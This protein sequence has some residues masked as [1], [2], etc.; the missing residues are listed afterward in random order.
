M[1][2]DSDRV[3][4][5]QPLAV[6]RSFYERLLELYPSLSDDHPQG[7]AYRGLLQYILFSTFRDKKTNRTLVPY[8]TVAS[9]VGVSPHQRGFSALAWLSAFSR[10]VLPLN[11]ST[12]RYSEGKA[13]VIAP[14]ISPAL[15]EACEQEAA[16]HQAE[17]RASER[18]WFDSGLPV[19]RRNQRL[20][21]QEYE[22]YLKRQ[23]LS[24]RMDHPARELLM[25]LVEQPQD[26]LLKVLRENWPAVRAAV[27][28]MPK[29]TE[30]E[31]MRRQWC[32]LLLIRLDGFQ[33]LYYASSPKTPRLFTI[34]ANL[35]QFPRDLR[36]MALAGAVECD[37]RAS[38]LAVVA[39]LWD[40]PSLQ[41]YL[42]SGVSVWQDLADGIGVPLEDYKPI[43]KAS[44]YSI[45][46]GMSRSEI[47]WQLAHGT[48]FEEGVG[49]AAAGRF[50]KLPIIAP[51][52]EARDHMLYKIGREC[53][54]YDAWGRW[55]YTAQETRPVRGRLRQVPDSPSVLSAIVQ[56]YELKIMLSVL[57]VIKSDRQIYLLSW[58]HDGVTLLL[59]NK[60]K[61]ER[62]IRRLKSVVQREAEALQVSTW[63]E[64]EQLS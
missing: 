39:R 23:S 25:Y 19:S 64:V 4:R 8:T 46:F 51:L 59:G 21:A 1:E 58:L 18:V 33:K 6:S 37:L 13:R 9:L 60:T 62:Y 26:R 32:E 5:L 31:W 49:Q 3:Y 50:L 56:S 43:L 11:P 55:L 2:P 16:Q 36:K 47:K 7:R 45:V 24:I 38:Q 57:P 28:A 61:A 29:R 44:I 35:H 48:A 12:Y 54:G 14:E 20:V 34:G 42:K 63:L 22:Q 10:D 17:G 41:A 53:G 27:T 40:I 30:R 15:L 52:L